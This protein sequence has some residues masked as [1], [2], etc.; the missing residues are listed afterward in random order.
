MYGRKNIICFVLATL[1]AFGLSSCEKKS[2]SSAQVTGLEK[3]LPNP[4]EK[5]LDEFRAEAD[6]YKNYDFSGIFFPEDITLIELDFVDV[7]G[8]VIDAF[9]SDEQFFDRK[10]MSFIDPSLRGF[11][12]ATYNQEAHLRNHLK[13]SVVHYVFLQ[14]SGHQKFFLHPAGYEILDLSD[15]FPLRA[16]DYFPCEEAAVCFKMHG[17]INTANSNQFY[18]QLQRQSK[19]THVDAICF[20]KVSTYVLP[21]EHSEKWS[22]DYA[23]RLNNCLN[24]FATKLVF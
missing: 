20:I 7:N 3:T 1:M 4:I 9:G 15:I 10:I 23:T 11:L 12:D 17:R 5:K 6:R 16:L 13:L 2:Q 19:D 24:Y 21:E 8:G 18:G 22:K 14:E